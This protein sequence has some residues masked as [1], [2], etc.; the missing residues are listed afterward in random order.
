MKVRNGFVS[1]SSSSSFMIK[2]TT[3]TAQVAT[4]MMNEMYNEYI[5]RTAYPGI[6]DNKVPEDFAKALEWLHD[7]VEYSE[8]I[9][10]PW[11]CNYET[12]IWKGTKNIHVDTCNNH[13]WSLLGGLYVEDFYDDEFLGSFLDLSDMQQTTKEEFREKQERQW[14]AFAAER[15]RKQN[16]ST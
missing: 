2:G 14:K 7:N 13:D 10:L 12:F 6:V 9:L 4:M 16:E 1:N 3:T 5:T 11:S 15:K 8:P